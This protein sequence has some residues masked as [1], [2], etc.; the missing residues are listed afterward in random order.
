MNNIQI[1]GN[2]GKLINPYPK[3]E[4]EQQ[5]GCATLNCDFVL[6]FQIPLIVPPNTL[7][8]F[9]KSDWIWR[10][11]KCGVLQTTEQD[12][13]RS[14]PLGRMELKKQGGENGS[15][16]KKR[17]RKPKKKESDDEQNPVS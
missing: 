1:P 2:K 11:P 13:P 16:A 8:L 17:K 9:D 15:I 14:T 7:I 5:F 3:E 10:C 4:Y 6:T 12:L